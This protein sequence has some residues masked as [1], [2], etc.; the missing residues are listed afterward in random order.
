MVAVNSTML[1]LGTVAPDF[2]LPDVSGKTVSL[3]DFKGKPL[4]VMFICNH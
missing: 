1:P 2:Q 3:A 4:V